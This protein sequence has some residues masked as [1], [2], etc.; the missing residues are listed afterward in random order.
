MADIIYYKFQLLSFSFKHIMKLP[1]TT[2]LPSLFSIIGY[3]MPKERSKYRKYSI[4]MLCEA[5]KIVEKQK[6]LSTK[7]QNK[8]KFRGVRSEIFFLRILSKSRKKQTCLNWEGR[9]RS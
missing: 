7:L 3:T 2:K 1:L 6:C 8:W 4:N 5:A 9:S